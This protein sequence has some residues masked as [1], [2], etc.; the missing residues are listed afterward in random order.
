MLK[1][2]ISVLYFLLLLSSLFWGKSYE[3][4]EQDIHEVLFILSLEEKITIMGDDSVF[5]KATFRAIGE[6]FDEIFDLFL[7]QN[8]LYLTKKDGLWLVSKMRVYCDDEGFIQ[9]DSYDISPQ[10]L[11]EK[12]SE[13]SGIPIMYDAIPTQAISVHVSNISVKEFVSLVMQSLGNYTVTD[14]AQVLRIRR[15]LGNQY[16]EIHTGYCS[17]Q[18]VA[19]DQESFYSKGA[20]DTVG[21]TE[22]T[23]KEPL[24]NADISR[25]VGKKVLETLCQVAGKEAVFLAPCNTLIDTVQLKEKS[26]DDLLNLFCV[27]LFVSAI[28]KD[29]LMYFVEGQDALYN[30][31]NFGKT[32]EL[33]RLA[34][35]KAQELCNFLQNR[36]E[37]LRFFVLSNNELFILANTISHTEIQTIIKTIDIM[38]K[39]YLISLQYIRSDDFLNLL[40]TGFESEAFTKT[41]SEGELFFNGTEQKYKQLLSLLEHIDIPQKQ[42]LYELLVLQVQDSSN[43]SWEPSLTAKPIAL[44][45]SNFVSADLGSVLDLQ[46]NVLTAFGIHFAT[47][48][49]TAINESKAKIF[50]DTSLHGLSGIPINFQNTN[51]YRYKDTAINPETGKPMY[52]GVTREI[53]SG[54]FLEVE[55]WVSGNGM[56]TTKVKATVSKRGADV[57]SSVGNPPPT[58]EKIITTQVRSKSG[59]T[60]ILSGLIQDDSVLIEQRTPFFSKIPFIGK[61]CTSLVNTREKTEMHIYLIPRLVGEENEANVELVNKNQEKMN[62]LS[63][64]IFMFFKEGVYNE[65]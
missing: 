13:V 21:T 63:E 38:Q 8:R 37:S 27:Q 57:S 33:Y 4:I 53:I 12:I 41:G 42:I 60:V 14:E 55:G 28:E 40:P 56:I 19:N 15:E 1:K 61:L 26:F 45:D 48:L 9:V 39:N 25:V 59:E 49:Q 18:E 24:Y 20:E 46:F 23:K 2:C 17:I 47:K 3:F 52:T 64:A 54:L 44:G 29:G 10:R 7:A 16:E 36:F 58:Y 31:K 51:T 35:I 62:E 43:F 34:Y 32:W 6:S 30:S 5:G 50:A 65:F 11:F 22:H